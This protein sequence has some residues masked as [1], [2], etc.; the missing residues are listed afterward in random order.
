M[1]R[2]RLQ[3]GD[4]SEEFAIDVPFA[5]DGLPLLIRFVEPDGVDVVDMP[6]SQRAAWEDY[7]Q[8]LGLALDDVL[9][10]HL[11]IAFRAAVQDE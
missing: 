7:A 4:N 11:D 5:P 9:R 6:P 8:R 3:H 1:G 10:V 2:E